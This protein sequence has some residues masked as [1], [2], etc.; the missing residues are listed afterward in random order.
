MNW[1]ISFA[2]AA[3][4]ASGAAYAQ[5]VARPDPA[6]PK[7]AAMDRPYESAFKDYRPYREA[8]VGRWREAN[9]EMGRIGGHRGHVPGQGTGHATPVKPAAPAPKGHGGHK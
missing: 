4:A 5:N 9:E 7:T 3:L 1:K 8:E 6:D 2:L